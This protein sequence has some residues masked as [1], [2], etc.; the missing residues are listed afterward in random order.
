MPASIGQQLQ[1]ARQAHGLSIEE[2]AQVTRIRPHYLK[3]L[4][5][6]DAS[7]LPSFV[8][9]RG[10]LRNY[11]SFL[12]LD[13]ARLT[14]QQPA[15]VAEPVP[16]A[17]PVQ[18]PPELEAVAVPEPSPLNAEKAEPAP[19]RK[20]SPKPALKPVVAVPPS[21]PEN[22]PLTPRTDEIFKE[23][24][25]QL[26]EQRERLSLP[27]ADLERYTHIRLHYLKALEEGD[28]ELL[29]SFTQARGMLNQYAQFL[30]LDTG[31]ILNR[32]ADALIARRSEISAGIPTRKSA[33][34][35]ATGRLHRFL[36]M[37]ALVGSA[38]VI[39]LVVFVFWG[40]SRV[41]D[42][43][44][45]S[46]PEPT[47]PSVAEVLLASPE[48]AAVP[49]LEPSSPALTD[50]TPS[51][52]EQTSLPPTSSVVE[53]A[54]PPLEPGKVQVFIVGLNRTWIKVNV[55]GKLAFT[56]RVTSGGAYPFTA[57]SRI[58]VTAANAGAI[59]V[60]LNQQ[61]LGSPGA[62]NESIT[63]VYSAEGAL[64]PTPTVT[65]T[66]TRTPRVSPTPTSTR[67][68]GGG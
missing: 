59:Q 64:L 53:A 13:F 63:L 8:Q 46:G 42:L 45:D 25:S 55:D 38:L 12:G 19:A 56:G 68:P 67:T 11:A 9:G 60:Y 6:D 2:A 28:F 7:G 17:P 26:K 10:F 1:H 65:P 40:A 43:T 16:P 3:A 44:G 5:A 57:S 47:P 22:T 61:D 36:T 49:I 52:P 21:K 30:S 20:G 31:Q 41:F 51:V 23:I 33:P 34:L 39:L 37:D 35:Q 14:G 58:E 50:T 66:P 29:P 24:G 54:M 62:W 27:L 15:A 48:S 18:S 4:E 32:F